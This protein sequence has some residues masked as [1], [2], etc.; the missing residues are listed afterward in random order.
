MKILWLA[1]K[2][3]D[4]PE[5]GGAEVVLK[6]LIDRQVSEGHGVTLLTS[7]YSGSSAHETLPN[8]LEIIRVGGNRYVH[9]LAALWYYLSHLRGQFDVVIETV[10]TA[11]YF[12]LLFR[13]RATGLAFYHQLA[14]EIWFFETR[15]PLSQLGYY[16]IEPFSTWL[17]GRAKAPLVTVSESTKLDLSRFGWDPSRTHIISQGLQYDPINTLNTAE[18]YDQ[19]T[20]LSF[21]TVRGMKRTLD[22][23]KA[24]ELA[25]QVIPDLQLK[26]AGS[27]F[28][29]YGHEALRYMRRS[30]YSNDIEY[31]GRVSQEHKL[32][33]MRRSHIITVTSV[34]EGWGL[35]VTEAASQG[36]PAVVYDADGLRDSVQ[37][38]HTGL[39]TRPTPEGLAEG[40]IKVLQ[41]AKLYHKLQKNAWQWSKTMTFDRSYQDFKQVIK[42][43]VL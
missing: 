14:R 37:D 43:A 33:L 3:Y 35:I 29:K 36:A 24:F 4:H 38:G 11:P 16:L 26:V 10:N 23:V 28:D 27:V 2:D 32:E 13:G 25:K 20:I 22:Q 15:S 18:K 9:P 31:L 1:W 21:G 8:G 19:P 40:I 7:R 30:R 41:N 39:V 12:S 34:K 5:R 6:E 42:E 17:L